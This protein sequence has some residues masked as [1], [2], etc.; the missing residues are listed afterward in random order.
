LVEQDISFAFDLA[1]RNYVLSQGKMITQGSPE[2]LLADESIRRTY[3]G[4]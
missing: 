4:L 3:L 1:P 2:E